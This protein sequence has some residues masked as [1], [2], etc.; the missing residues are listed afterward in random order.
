VVNHLD[1]SIFA[2]L[3]ILLFHVAGLVWTVREAWSSRRSMRRGNGLG[4]TRGE[5]FAGVLLTL[6]RA[7]QTPELA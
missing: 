3:M 5:R 4:N 6:E 7:D 1:T 2:F